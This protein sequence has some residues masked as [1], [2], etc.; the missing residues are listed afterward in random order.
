[1]NNNDALRD[2]KDI[3]SMMERSSRFLSISGWGVAAVGIIA[4]V[5]AWI[6]YKVFSDGT[7]FGYTHYLWAY[8]TKV[9]VVGSL[10]LVVFCGMIVFFSSVIMARRRGVKFVFDKTMRRTVLNFSIPLL[11]GGILC[12]ALVLEGHY[13]LTSSI[14]LI[15]YGL[16]LINCHH[17]SHPVLGTL[18]YLELL[19]GLVDCFTVTHALLLWAVGFGLLHLIFGIYLIVINKRNFSTPM[20]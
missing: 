11:A 16:A 3:R 8:K 18:G 13:G 7:L 9:A 4:I 1:M 14:M 5:A 20:P 6:A 12:L 17:F 15:F 2:I 19:L 10:I